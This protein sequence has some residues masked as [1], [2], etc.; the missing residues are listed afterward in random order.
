MQFLI[1][2]AMLVAALVSVVMGLDVV[3]TPPVKLAKPAL[4]E[5]IRHEAA[6][7]QT[8]VPSPAPIAQQPATR[9]PAPQPGVAQQPAPQIY[10]PEGTTAQRA[11]PAQAPLCNVAACA[12]AY[13]SFTASDCTYQPNEGP[14]KLCTRQ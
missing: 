6:P 5:P 11:E 13:R 9:A 10:Q 1:Y 2:A 7:V 14:R 12:A 3:S 8:A 4:V